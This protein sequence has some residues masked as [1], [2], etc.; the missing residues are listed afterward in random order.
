[1]Q[2]PAIVLEKLDNQIL[3][4]LH[5]WP[6]VSW[7]TLGALLNIDAATASRHW[8][9]MH[10][11]GVAWF[12]AYTSSKTRHLRGADSHLAA[13]NSVSAV[14]ELRVSP[15]ELSSVFEQ[16]QVLDEL[17]MIRATLGEWNIS[18]DWRGSSI[19]DLA[20]FVNQR[21]AR[22]EGVQASRSFAITYVPI[23]G[24]SWRYEG[25]SPD[26]E[27]KLRKM[28][29]DDLADP[30][31]FTEYWHP[32]DDRII[33][34]IQKDARMSYTE[35]ARRTDSVVGTVKRHLGH[36][37]RN[38]DLVIRCDQARQYSSHPVT[39][40]YFASV[41]AANSSEVIAQLAELPEIR[42]CVVLLGRYNLMMNVWL[43][44]LIDASRF[45]AKLARRLP[46]VRIEERD[47]VTRYY[48][49][50]GARIRED[51]R[52]DADPQS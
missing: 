21:L 10:E 23:D 9:R 47:L 40:R 38:R 30:V 17:N 25:L 37:L 1:M 39:V 46:E 27:A 50:N 52:N 48:V 3:H 15:S 32:I 14:V 35:M 19:D 49:H 42:A 5:I 2:E 28:Q 4:A 41:P 26:Q 18:L 16:L 12:S 51:G 43:G 29:R 44:S 33:E 20:T 34:L 22:I 36:L 6:R 24:S 11:S 8:A 45:E 7:A 31:P 13:A